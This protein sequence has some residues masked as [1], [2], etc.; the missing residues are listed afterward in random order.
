MFGMG[1]GNIDAVT[2]NTTCSCWAPQAFQSEEADLDLFYVSLGSSS[3]GRPSAVASAGKTVTLR[4]GG[5]VK[6][7]NENCFSCYSQLHIDV[8]GLLQ[9]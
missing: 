9:K 3:G 7:T 6:N 5:T 8:D 4:L 2:N 1:L